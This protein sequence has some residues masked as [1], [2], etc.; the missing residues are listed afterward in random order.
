MTEIKT[1][2][3]M[4]LS[5]TG[6]NLTDKVS[7][8]VSE[9]LL[10]WEPTRKEAALLEA[11]GKIGLNRSV[12]AICEE[13]ET[14]RETYYQ[15]Q[16]KPGFRA[17][18]ADKARQVMESGSPGVSAAVT[19]K[20]IGGDMMATRLHL[21][22]TG[23]IGS[24][25]NVHLGDKIKNPLNQYN[26]QPGQQVYG[27][28]R[29]IVFRAANEEEFKITME[30]G[31]RVAAEMLER[32]ERGEPPLTDAQQLQAIKIGTEKVIA[33]RAAKEAEEVVAGLSEVIDVTSVE[34]AE[35]D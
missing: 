8:T 29:D 3:L 7:D 32:E 4:S 10:D 5:D 20:A 16:K 18:W 23:A 11:A 28:H 2:H 25:V 30:I 14:S 6:Q 19:Q 17:A 31:E 26:Q 34:V 1:G 15:A 33:E 22:A 35:A 12:S 21:Q 13:A 24:G 9:D 27:D